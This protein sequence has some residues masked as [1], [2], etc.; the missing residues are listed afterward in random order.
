MWRPSCAARR[1][2]RRCIEHHHQPASFMARAA[3]H[4]SAALLQ[5][6][7]CPS[8]TTRRP[9]TVLRDGGVV[10]LSQARRSGSAAGR[11]SKARGAKRGAEAKA[12]KGAAGGRMTAS[13]R[14]RA[15]ATP[16]S[17]MQRS[18]SLLPNS[19]EADER[20]AEPL[21]L[22]DRGSRSP[23]GAA[24]WVTEEKAVDDERLCAFPSSR[25]K[26][27]RAPARRGRGSTRQLAETAERGGAEE[28]DAIDEDVGGGGGELAEPPTE[29][30]ICATAEDDSYDLDELE[31]GN[32]RQ[33]RGSDAETR[34]DGALEEDEE[35]GAAVT[36]WS[37]HGGFKKSDAETGAGDAD[38]TG[39]PSSVASD[40]RAV[41]SATIDEEMASR[42]L[43]H[44]FPELAAEYAAVGD[45]ANATPASE[46]MT[47]SAVVA[48][49]RCAKCDHVW[50]SGVFVR[51]ILKNECPRCAA[52][53]TLTLAKV[54]PD[55][56]Q[57][58]D[59]SRNNPFLRPEEI[60]SDSKQSVFWNCPMCRE[61]YAARVKDRVMDKVRCPSCALL[62]S[63]SADE[64]ASEESFVLQEWHPLKNGDLSMEQVS[65]TDTKTKVWW[66]CAG[67][68]H[69]WEAS[70][71]TRLKRCR[72]TRRGLCPACHGKGITDLVE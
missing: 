31:R 63:R 37:R 12:E 30:P 36:R 47:D 64:L 46:V 35:C 17:A 72:R 70:L 67:C 50:R 53:R 34:L 55:L 39:T 26:H 42:Y 8:L 4:S 41:D 56:L 28:T 1:V 20:L 7:C 44:A 10:A 59:G 45:G 6:R 5:W 29:D 60:A 13:S 69:E 3:L 61:S 54:R 33:C 48:A 65:P 57:L 2:A 62:H 68:G 16:V 43:A 24:E 19:L 15:Q 25:Q 21:G 9:Q 23:D 49:W 14:S 51:C 27:S 18:S 22:F 11:A 38:G 71:A 32:S 52:N 66:L 58:W 40:Q